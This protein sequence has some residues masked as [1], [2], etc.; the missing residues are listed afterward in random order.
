MYARFL[1]FTHVSSPA[2]S[3]YSSRKV[4]STRPLSPLVPSLKN[5]TV[6]SLL[7]VCN[8]IA[9]IIIAVDFSSKISHLQTFKCVPSWTYSFFFY[10]IY[11]NRQHDRHVTKQPRLGSLSL[12]F[13]FPPLSP[14]NFLVTNVPR[15]A[16][17]ISSSVQ[18]CLAMAALWS[19]SR[20]FPTPSCLWTPSDAVTSGF[21][22]VAVP[23]H[24]YHVVRSYLGIFCLKIQ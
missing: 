19:G 12:S 21:F 1:I 9:I 16:L 7:G 13:Y 22:R 18:L 8:I 6:K 23:T 14:L 11:I 10:K 15:Y 5:F 24:V 4:K 20:R 2:L 17:T 3:N